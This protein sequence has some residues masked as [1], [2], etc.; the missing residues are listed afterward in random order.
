MNSPLLNEKSLEEL[1]NKL[2][3]E[4]KTLEEELARFAER[5][6]AVKGDW[7]ARYSDIGT[8]WDENAQEV[9]D[10][11]TRLPLER[12]LEKRLQGVDAALERIKSESYG[13]CE[14]DGKPIALERLEANPATTRCV[15]HEK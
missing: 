9:T 7:Q 13:F 10:F 4:K 14:V 8:D 3:E 15:D 12:T 5:N 6:P 1:A 11:A 2:R